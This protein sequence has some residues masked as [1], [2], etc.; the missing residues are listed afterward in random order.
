[1]KKIIINK[2]TF[3][4]T[5][6]YQDWFTEERMPS[7]AQII[8]IDDTYYASCRKEDFDCIDGT[9]SFNLEKYNARIEKEQ[10]IKDDYEYENKIV[11]LIRQK[12]NVNQELA[13]LRQRD[14]KPEEFAEY[15]E[16]V[17]QC[18]AQVKNGI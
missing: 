7:D 17:E 10:S 16:Y 2:T 9:Y 5:L 18:K 8:E 13:I 4:K 12:Y 15:H 14:T 3:D 6:I 11:T 1:M